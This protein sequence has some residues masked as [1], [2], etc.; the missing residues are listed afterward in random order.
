MSTASHRTSCTAFGAQ[1]C[2]NHRCATRI[3]ARYSHASGTHATYVS[4]SSAPQDPPCLLT[5]LQLAGRSLV[6]SAGT[7]L[8]LP[9]PGDSAAS[10]RWRLVRF[11]PQQRCSCCHA[12]R[13]PEQGWM[14]SECRQYHVGPL[15]LLLLRLVLRVLVPLWSSCGGV[16]TSSPQYIS[17]STRSRVLSLDTHILLHTM[18]HNVSDVT[19]PYRI[20]KRKH[21]LRPRSM[22]KRSRNHAPCG[23]SHRIQLREAASR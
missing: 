7:A 10:C 6:P 3:G 12:A 19:V 16:V 11:L 20:S 4:A 2:H 17:F 14:S 9:A 5:F 23:S 22:S 13:A 18:Y 15:A 21:R 1:C 8:L